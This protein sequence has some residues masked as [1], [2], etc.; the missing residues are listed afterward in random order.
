MP[1]GSTGPAEPS[2]EPGWCV[3]I[4]QVADP[5][6][7]RPARSL[8]SASASSYRDACAIADGWACV[9]VLVLGAWPS[10]LVLEVFEA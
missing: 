1:D 6:P 8:A 3:V 10:C 9:V 4:W 7:Y 2:A 5:D